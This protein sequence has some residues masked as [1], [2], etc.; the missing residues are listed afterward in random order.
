MMTLKHL[1]QHFD[2]SNITYD[3]V[4]RN[5]LCI[6]QTLLSLQEDGL[7]L[8]R[9]GRP[10]RLYKPGHINLDKITLSLCKTAT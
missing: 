2:R 4:G 1:T 8:I 5:Q 10:E 7:L 3:L 6:G 9:P